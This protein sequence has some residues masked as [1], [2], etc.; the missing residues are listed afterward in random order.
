[1]WLRQCFIITQPRMHMLALPLLLRDTP[2]PE[3]GLPP[4]EVGPVVCPCALTVD[5]IE[6]RVSSQEGGA[7]GFRSCPACCLTLCQV[8]YLPQPWFPY[9]WPRKTV[10][11]SYFHSVKYSSVTVYAR[12]L[13]YRFLN[14]PLYVSKSAGIY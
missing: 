13:L 12:S 1:M 10:I 9:L 3:P 8:A 7:A 11:L 14:F 2:A 6:S 4:G 5:I